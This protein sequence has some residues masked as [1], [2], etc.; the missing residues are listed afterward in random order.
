MPSRCQKPSPPLN[1]KCVENWVT[2]VSSKWA[3]EESQGVF[4]IKL[5][6]I[7]GWSA[8][9]STYIWFFSYLGGATPT[10]LEAWVKTAISVLVGGAGFTHIYNL[11]LIPH[12]EFSANHLWS[13]TL[14]VSGI[15]M[16]I[17]S[18]VIAALGQHD[19]WRKFGGVFAL[20]GAAAVMLGAF[21]SPPRGAQ[22][23][24]KAD[25]PASGGSTA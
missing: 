23:T 16:A 15:C 10:L 22:P 3:P 19:M 17:S 7:I 2:P 24:L 11:Y 18:T 14:I 5:L 12:R 4:V 20:V 25:G 21:L 6:A 13:V 1:R 9:I 8:V